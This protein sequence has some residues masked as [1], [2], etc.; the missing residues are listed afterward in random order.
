VLIVALAEPIISRLAD[1]STT[2][3]GLCY[4]RN[5]N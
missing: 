2:E 4:T 5:C 1:H 3:I